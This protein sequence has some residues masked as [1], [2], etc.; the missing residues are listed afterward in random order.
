MSPGFK[1]SDNSFMHHFKCKTT[2]CFQWLISK[3]VLLPKPIF[4][5]QSRSFMPVKSFSKVGHGTQTVRHRPQTS[6]WNGPQGQCQ[7]RFSW[8]SNQLIVSKVE[9]LVS[10]F[11]CA[12]VQVAR[13][14]SGCEGLF[15]PCIRCCTVTGALPILLLCSVTAQT[16]HHTPSKSWPPEPPHK[17]DISCYCKYNWSIFRA[18]QEKLCR[19]LLELSLSLFPKLLL[20]QSAEPCFVNLEHISTWEIVEIQITVSRFANIKT[21]LS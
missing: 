7:N 21:L 2:Y 8:L 4:C 14:C 18:S 16:A 17:R 6:I 9:Q 10:L 5:A 1:C 3:T 19:P 15:G 13:I 12:E 11:M 20:N